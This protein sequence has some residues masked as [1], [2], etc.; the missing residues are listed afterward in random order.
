MLFFPKVCTHNKL[1]HKQILRC[2]TREE[3]SSK[4]WGGGEGDHWIGVLPTLIRE[5]GSLMIDK[6]ENCATIQYDQNK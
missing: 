5:I 3:N 2:I 4:R 1:H 6:D